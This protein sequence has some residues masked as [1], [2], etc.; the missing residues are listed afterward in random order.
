LRVNA[1]R[2]VEGNNN[3]KAGEDMDNDA[4]MEEIG[5]GCLTES[6]VKY[7]EAVYKFIIV[8]VRGDVR[9]VLRRDLGRR[10][11]W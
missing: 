6:D 10:I 1:K 5:A 7:D 11:V 2:R 8:F 4:M 3:T 9:G